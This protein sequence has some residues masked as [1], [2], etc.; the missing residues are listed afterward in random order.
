MKLWLPG[1]HKRRDGWAQAGGFG[2]GIRRRQSAVE[3]CRLIGGDIQ[4][5]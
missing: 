3:V 4:G 2:S 5:L 1:A